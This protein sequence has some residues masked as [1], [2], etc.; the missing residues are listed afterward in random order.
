MSRIGKTPIPLPSD[1]RCTL[2]GDH[3]TVQGPKG[4]L[5]RT[6]HPH[7]TVTL[8]QSD[9]KEMLAVSVRD[10]E[11]VRDRA[12]WGLFR[13]LLMNMVLGVTQGFEKKMEVIG[14][15]YKVAGGGGKLTLDVGYSHPVRLSCQQ[16]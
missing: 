7:V 12:L 13:T 1:V 11:K 8:G 3:V 10:P 4:T 6:L 14:V 15:G 16:A 5:T 2:V 9:G